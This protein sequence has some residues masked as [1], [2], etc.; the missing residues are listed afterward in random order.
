MNFS[1]LMMSLGELGKIMQDVENYAGKL[2]SSIYH[3]KPEISF[4]QIRRGNSTKPNN[5]LCVAFVFGSL[6]TA[7]FA[8]RVRQC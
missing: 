8:V 3:A 1:K 4:W 5:F 7:L 6:T 2:S